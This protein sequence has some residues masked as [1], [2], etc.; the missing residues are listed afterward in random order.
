MPS[1][2]LVPGD[3]RLILHAPGHERRSVKTLLHETNPPGPVTNRFVLYF[4]FR[5]GPAFGE[6]TGF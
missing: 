1:L 6:A 2:R 5:H 4:P 3:H